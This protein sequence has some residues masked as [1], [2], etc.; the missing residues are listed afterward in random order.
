M[1]ISVELPAGYSSPIL[2]RI[3]SRENNIAE[4]WKRL[5]SHPYPGRSEITYLKSR[6]DLSSAPES[7][8]TIS[9]TPEG[10]TAARFLLECP[11][12]ALLEF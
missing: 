1:E 7:E 6:N 3:D 5:G 10:K 12:A 2:F 4:E 9:T 8:V 11:G